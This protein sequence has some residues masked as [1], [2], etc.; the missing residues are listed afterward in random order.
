LQKSQ[1]EAQQQ[2]LQSPPPIHSPRYTM[3]VPRDRMQL[4]SNPQRI[5]KI[6]LA[7]NHH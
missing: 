1:Q 3:P 7:V 2:G 5:E 4:M 6:L